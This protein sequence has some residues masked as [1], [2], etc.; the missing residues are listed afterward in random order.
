MSVSPRFSGAGR[1]PQALE[2]G[3]PPA[4]VPSDGEPPTGTRGRGHVRVVGH[5]FPRICG[6]ARVR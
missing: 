2:V 6:S 1:K 4:V 3:N 5:S